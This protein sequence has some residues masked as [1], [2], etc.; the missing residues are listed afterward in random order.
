MNIFR[1]FL[2][3]HSYD[4]YRAV[5]QSE[6]VRMGNSQLGRDF[7]LRFDRP[8]EGV[9]LDIG[10]RCLLSNEFIFES[11]GGKVTVG[12]GVFINGGTKI[13]SRSSVDIGDSVMIA[14]GCLIYDHDSHS[15]SYLD[16]IADHNQVLIDFLSGNMVA[17]KNWS[18]VATA[19]IRIC[20]HA[21]LGF[22]V[23]VLKGVTIGE[24]SIVGARSVVTKDLPPW[25]IAAG[26]L[27]RV[28][29]EVPL[30]LRKSYAPSS[31]RE[32]APS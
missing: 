15:I 20:D 29:K 13:I 26:N 18:T 25:T 30:E 5:A 14:W 12:N 31:N 28:V 9:A 17:N 22:D 27:A 16:R 19:P 8:H 3:R 32:T 7:R 24:G 4:P 23:V 2:A 11:T 1:R 21:W 6:N 10:D